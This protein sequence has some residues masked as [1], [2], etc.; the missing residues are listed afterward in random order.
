MKRFTIYRYLGTEF[1]MSFGVSFLFFF[2]IFFVNQLLV[3]AEDILS[4]SV[5]FFDV[6][7]LIFFSFPAIIAFSFPFASLVGGLMAVGRLSGDNEMLAMQASGFPLIRLAVPFLILGVVFSMISF[8]MND[9]FLPLGTIKFT[10]LYKSILASNPELELESNSVKQYQNSV[11]ITGEVNE[12]GIDRITILDRDEQ[13]NKRTIIA[14]RARLLQSTEQIG[15]I[16][17]ILEEVFIHTPREKIDQEFEY[18]I[19]ERMIYNILLKDISVSVKT[20]TP[21]EMSSRDVYDRIQEKE[22]SFQENVLRHLMARTELFQAALSEY[23]RSPDSRETQ[24]RYFGYQRSY[25]KQMRDR[26]LQLHKIEFN[27]KLALP[28][29][30][31]IFLVFAF[32]V[33][34]LSRRSGRSVGFGIG[35]LITAIYW[36]ILFAG[37]NLALRND[38]SP[39]L[40]IWMGNILVLISGVIVF[41][42]RSRL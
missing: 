42:R 8:I 32:P 25:E 28:I 14:K 5:P 36:G 18:S 10:N 40:S 41:I 17:L 29:G 19:S 38:L 27:K 26:S 31:I 21:M 13:K 15:V 6:V 12:D 4:K 30:C 35:L 2:F 3:M 23:E 20:L 11:I 1:L 9:F 16:S 34:L 22:S 33:G 7:Q 37:Q 39:V 24:N